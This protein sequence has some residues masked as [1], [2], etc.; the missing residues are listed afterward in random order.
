MPET[1]GELYRVGSERERGRERGG[2]RKSERTRTGK[3]RNSTQS[4]VDNGQRRLEATVVGW[5][6]TSSKVDG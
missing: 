5:S 2:Q 4:T 3:G 1:T 6:K